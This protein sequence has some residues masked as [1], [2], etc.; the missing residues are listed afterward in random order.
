MSIWSS[1]GGDVTGID[2]HAPDADQYTGT[3][4]RHIHVDLA[5]AAGFGSPVARLNISSDDA[6]YV[7]ECVM[8]DR[9][10][11]RQLRAN[12]DTVL[13]ILDRRIGPEVA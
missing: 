11:L 1:V 3:G 8:L 9:A 4:S 13:G 12:I 6:P 10:N 7:D 5:E 2:M